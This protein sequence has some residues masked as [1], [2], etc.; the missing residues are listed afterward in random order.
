ME[1]ST[2]QTHFVYTVKAVLARDI[3]HH[4]LSLLGSSGTQGFQQSV[5]G[6]FTSSFVQRQENNSLQQPPMW[7]N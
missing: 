2:S 6:I 1:N 4:K 5:H 3:F 7:I